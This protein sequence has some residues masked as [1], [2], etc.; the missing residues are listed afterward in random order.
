T[1]EDFWLHA[2]WFNQQYAREQPV[3]SGIFDLNRYQNR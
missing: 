3:L 2:D 1:S